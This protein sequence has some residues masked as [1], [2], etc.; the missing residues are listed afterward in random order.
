MT[1]R[2]P[3]KIL[4]LSCLLLAAA[5]G[6][7]R[8]AIIENE[9]DPGS[10][11]AQLAKA[12]SP[13]E[14][15]SLLD[16]LSAYRA[17]PPLALTA[18]WIPR[19]HP[20]LASDDP[21]IAAKAA[22]L[23]VR[24]G[25]KTATAALVSLLEAPDPMIRLSAASSLQKLADPHTFRPLLRAAH[26][27]N[28]AVRAAAAE[29]L[30]AIAGLSVHRES[31]V[32]GLRGLTR[33][34][35][36][37]VRAGATRAL[38]EAGS[39]RETP[40]LIVLL[41]DRETGVVTAAASALGRLGERSAVPALIALLAEGA[42]DPRLAAARSLGYL[43]DSRAVQPLVMAL[44]DDD[45]GLRLVSLKALG[46]LGDPAAIPGILEVARSPNVPLAF[47]LPSALARVYRPE[48]WERFR[49]HLDD[50]N[51]YVREVICG[52]LGQSGERRA[53]RALIHALQDPQ[54]GVRASAARALSLIGA[55]E[56]LRPLQILL[57]TEVD[58]KVRMQAMQAISRLVIPVL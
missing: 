37:A 38:G 54:P 34:L 57:Q 5:A 7:G 42:Q 12:A 23:L 52:A 18:P 2:K 20:Y 33:D 49:V 9:V 29:A 32:E 3:A 1:L 39:A 40:V 43:G 19:I 45:F 41:G 15:L 26:D 35:D 55:P 28:G 30:G 48:A 46:L 8:R 25:D 36:G 10:I 17:V 53:A 27:D 22:D 31:I 47:H 16:S 4:T 6:C 50:P 56:G 58:R 51:A 13:D 11:V 44:E 24:W 14:I 21:V